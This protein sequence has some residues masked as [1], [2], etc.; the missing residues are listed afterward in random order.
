MTPFLFALALSIGTGR[1]EAP[2]SLKA[3]ARS[4]SGQG[5]AVS[6]GSD[7]RGGWE[8]WVESDG[9]VADATIKRVTGRRDVGSIRLLQGGFGDAGVR[10]IKETP[11]L[12]TVVLVSD[13]LTD[14]CT[15]PLSQLKA[16]VKLDLNRARLTKSGLTRLTR[17]KTL[18]RLYLYNAHVLPN[19]LL[20]LG[21]MQRLKVLSLPKSVPASVVRRLR[22]K[23]P[24]TDIDQ[25]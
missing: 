22:E 11:R 9:P 2:E 16:L 19:D 4:L 23:L 8:L 5:L 13:R 3:L 25:I 17:I 1:Q 21:T 20:V 6:V 12:H 18:E 15:T 14:D 10:W 7:D 24:K